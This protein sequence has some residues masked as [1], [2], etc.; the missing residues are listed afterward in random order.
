MKRPAMAIQPEHVPIVP[1]DAKIE[2]WPSQSGLLRSL[3]LNPGV[4]H[5]LGHPLGLLAGELLEL[6][7]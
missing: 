7:G 1:T 3:G 5:K 4:A 2:S 6:L